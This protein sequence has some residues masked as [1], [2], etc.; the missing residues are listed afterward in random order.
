MTTKSKFP[1]GSR[2]A[3]EESRKKK[4]RGTTAQARAVGAVCGAKK[5]SGGKC[6]MA[7]GWGTPHLGVGACRLHGGSTPSHVKA[8][9]TEELRLLLGKPTP[10]SPLDAILKCISIVHGETIWLSQQMALLEDKDFVEDTMVGKQ[11]H[12]YARERSHRLN[13]L[14]RYSQIALSLGIAERAVKMA[15]IYG[16]LLYDYTKGV[17]DEL[18]PHLDEEGRA[19]APN[20]VRKHLIA[21]DSG[22]SEAV[23]AGVKQLEAA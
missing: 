8:A 5:K 21:L 12:L 20:I 16:Q 4:P 11:F 23:T 14:V 7:A 22:R 3:L 18:W 1:V 9:A 10:I 2:R 19:K 17:L 15:E 6:T 13:Q